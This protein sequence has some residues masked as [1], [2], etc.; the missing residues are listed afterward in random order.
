M[1]R[2]E[3]IKILGGSAGAVLT[4]LVGF[5]KKKDVTPNNTN[6]ELKLNGDVHVTVINNDNGNKYLFYT[7]CVLVGAALI[8]FLTYSVWAE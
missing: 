7:I 8:G 6:I 3:I 2:E 4:T 5:L 1:S